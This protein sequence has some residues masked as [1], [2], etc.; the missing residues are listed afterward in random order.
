[1][2]LRW[3]LLVSDFSQNWMRLIYFSETS[4]LSV[5]INICSVVV[6]LLHADRQGETDS[7][8]FFFCNFCKYVYGKQKIGQRKQRKEEEKK[9]SVLLDEYTSRPIKVGLVPEMSQ[10]HV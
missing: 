3:P 4:Q 2:S 7:C 6:K 10:G 5:L 8:I 1:M 9:Q